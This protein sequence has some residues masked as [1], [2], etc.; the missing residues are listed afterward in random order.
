MSADQAVV[1][2]VAASDASAADATQQ[3]ASTTAQSTST[4]SEGPETD[5]GSPKA[6]DEPAQD[7]Q[8]SDASQQPTTSP[9]GT[10]KDDNLT[11]RALV[12]SKEAGII[13][14]RGGSTIAN[15]RTEAGV[16]AGVSKVVQGVADRI[17]SVGG[18]VGNVSKAYSIVA[19]TILENPVANAGGAE[20]VTSAPSSATT[21]VRLLISH[22]LI[23]SVIGK[24]GAKIRQIQ[25]TS[26]ARMVASK[27]M[28]PQSTERIV[29][30]TGTA[31]GIRLAVAEI[32]KCLLE[33]WE[34]SQGTVLYHPGAEGLGNGAAHNTGIGALN[35]GFPGMQGGVLGGMGGAAAFGG[36]RIGSGGIMGPG[37]AFGAQR[38]VPSGGDF[39]SS[40]NSP[41]SRRT[42]GNMGPGADAQDPNYRE[43]K[44]SIPADMVGCII[45]RGGTKINEIRRLS[46]SR[47]T[48]AKTAHD[49][50]GERL[51]VISGLPDQNEKAL[52]LLYNQL[53]LE[54]NRRV[55]QSAQDDVPPMDVAGNTPQA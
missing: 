39:G 55:Q 23:G 10:A 22:L 13:I 31:E 3:T 21:T 44:I 43:Q 46:G 34:R 25:E 20:V 26:G 41:Q 52:Y 36:R 1:D 18:S 51:F 29:E 11:L 40:A 32:A 4:A 12:S 2:A 15:V 27:E 14:G 30:V 37:G 6:D 33:D 48:I 49:E 38:R 24:G 50:T 8:S 7:A 5:S 19:Q 42:S 53:E 35:N 17:L 9:D 28:L 16:K 47:I 54:K 45:G